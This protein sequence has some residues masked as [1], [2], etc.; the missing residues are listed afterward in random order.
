VVSSVGCLGLCHGGPIA[1]VWPD[2]TFY[3]NASPESVRRIVGEHVTKGRVV[4]DLCIARRSVRIE[5][6]AAP[7]GPSQLEAAR[8]PSL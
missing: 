1:V 8:D 6:Q 4:D 5:G 3:G 2:G 7:I